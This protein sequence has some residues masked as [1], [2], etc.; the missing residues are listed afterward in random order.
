MLD[1]LMKALGLTSTVAS[2]KPQV[3]QAVSAVPVMSDI[4]QAVPSVPVVSNAPLNDETPVRGLWGEITMPD[5]TDDSVPKLLGD[6]IHSAGETISDGLA[7]GRKIIDRSVDVVTGNAQ[8]AS[9]DFVAGI[10]GT[11]SAAN[12][13]VDP[14]SI[15]DQE[16]AEAMLKKQAAIKEHLDNLPPEDADAVDKVV[17][18][19][20]GMKPDEFRALKSGPKT[21]VVE[22]GNGFLAG[23][24]DGIP[25]KEMMEGAANALGDRWDDPAIRNALI[26]YTGAR[27]MGYSGS[28]SG[29]AAGQVLLKGWDNEAKLGAKTADAQAKLGAKNAIDLSK[30]IEYVDQSGRFHKV[31][32]SENG[33]YIQDPIS[34]KSLEASKLKWRPKATGEKGLEGRKEAVRL[35]V[36]SLQDSVLS[37]IR[38]NKRTEDNDGGFE[39]HNIQ[40]VEQMFADAGIAD[41]LVN[42]YADAYGVGALERGS[43][44]TLIRNSMEQL[45]RDVAKNGGEVTIAS[46]LGHLD[47]MTI[48]GSAKTIPKSVY[49]YK[50]DLVSS[51]AM[52]DLSKKI[53]NISQ[54]KNAAIASISES[55]T[56]IETKMK[57]ID[58]ISKKMSLDNV[59]R[60]LYAEYD[61]LASSDKDFRSYWEGQAGDSKGYSPFIMWLSDETDAGSRQKNWLSL[62][63]KHRDLL[64]LGV[65][66]KTK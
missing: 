30:T 22:T 16:Q 1:E 60:K 32:A 14:G 19:A 3:P 64:D 39:A 58:E 8:A 41:Q 36:R 5:Q 51:D 28:G 35:N 44:K 18:L 42:A 43:S 47:R 50:G 25:F 55:N 9:D 21:Q 15:P 12:W 10:T 2:Q 66:K 45:A 26:Y 7:T 31:F 20:N 61:K 62:G 63:I 29:M 46:A 54:G 4:P 59:T 34:G 56:A 13:D 24:F 52:S 37:G 23:L 40:K 27:L 11:E 65:T 17:K 33:K 48:T 53:R 6:S 38:S 57:R 49:N